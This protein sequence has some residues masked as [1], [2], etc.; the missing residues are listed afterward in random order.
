MEDTLMIDPL[1]ERATRQHVLGAEKHHC[2]I[3]PKNRVPLI[4]SRILD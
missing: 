1:P 2:E 3:H 4:E